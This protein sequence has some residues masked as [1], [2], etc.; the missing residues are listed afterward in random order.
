MHDWS[1]S[2]ETLLS[3]S[4]I[5][6]QHASPDVIVRRLVENAATLL[7]ADAGLAGLALPSAEHDD[8]VM[9][10]EAYWHDGRW[11][12]RPRQWARLEGLPGY[13][14]ETEFPYITND[15]RSDKLADPAFPAVARALCAPIRGS[16]ETLIGFFELHKGPD[17]SEFIPAGRRLSRVAGQHG[18]DHDSE[19]SAWSESS[20]TR[21]SR[22]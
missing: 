21:T 22:F 5:I 15:Y 8:L 3:F 13:V 1:K 6:S 16:D 9:V 19:R 11:Q 4:S 14:L 2:L 17:G 7:R 18:G 10:G 20:R 12:P